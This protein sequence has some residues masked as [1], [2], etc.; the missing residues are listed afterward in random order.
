MPHEVTVL[1]PGET[2]RPP[3]VAVPRVRVDAGSVTTVGRLLSVVKE[4][5]AL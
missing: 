3:S 1:W 5:G 2:I 4:S